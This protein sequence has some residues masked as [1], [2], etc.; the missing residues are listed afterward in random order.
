MARMIKYDYKFMSDKKVGRFGF[1][2]KELADLQKKLGKINEKLD[3]AKN[4]HDLSFR[5][6]PYDY[7]MLTH[8]YKLNKILRN[9]FDN[10]VVVGIGG[11]ELGAKAIHGALA[12][13]YANQLRNKK[14]LKIYFAGDTTDP[15]PVLDL[16]KIIDLKKTIFFIVS[17]S[18]LTIEPLANF[19]FLRKKVI[20]KV[21]KSHHAN[22]F[23]VSTLSN[24]NPLYQIAKRE[25]YLVL[26]HYAGG[27][28]YSALSI[29][30]LL[31]ALAAGF[32][33][34]NLLKGA[35]AIDK[36]CKSNKL[37][38]N[39]PALFAALQYL[40]YK[41]RQQNISILMPYSYYLDDFSFWFRQLMAESVGKKKLGIT[42]IASLGPSDQHSQI[43]L[44][45]D[46]PHDKVITFVRVE[47][48]RFD[49][50]IPKYKNSEISY[51]GGH[52]LNSVLKIEHLATSVSL[53]ENK[54][55]NGTIILPELNE[56]YLGQ[57]F[58]FFEMAVVYLG[59]FFNINVFDQPG[60]E[61][62]KKYM[63]GLLGRKGFEKEAREIRRYI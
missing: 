18:G 11:S 50:Q 29:N 58:F 46:G 21:G 35:R 52:G 33:I 30:G 49:L 53:M 8:L 20:E 38:K 10:M 13:D 6:L 17:R 3:K 45:M 23:I 43:Q 47:K 26:P 9:H 1:R 63:Y 56:F 25:G 51:L 61:Q 42:P 28:R 39:S 59:E 31:P 54:R 48:I 37:E 16:L 12:G 15:K 5:A 44:Y 27:G 14:G 19:L 22:H 36:I 34:K 2:Q 41:K 24:K 7:K 32:D 57:L 55:P 4:S 40:A 62:S 60:V